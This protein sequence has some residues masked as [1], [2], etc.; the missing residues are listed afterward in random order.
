MI[1]AAA[2][3]LLLPAMALATPAAAQSPAEPT[4]S[5]KGLTNYSV[6]AAAHQA[7]LNLN[8]NLPSQAATTSGFT[9]APMPN[10]N[11]SAP[12]AAPKVGPEFSG[13]LFNVHDAGGVS[14]GYTDGSHYSTDLE[15]RRQGVGSS[16]APTLSLKI[17]FVYANTNQL[18][19]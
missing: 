19:P 17:P 1:R 10:L 13:T 6:P 9:P 16:F 7:P 2:L 11:V 5:T 12:T 15:R 3:V 14:N 8:L 18:P 4:K